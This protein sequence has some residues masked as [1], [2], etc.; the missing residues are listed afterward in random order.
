MAKVDLTRVL[1]NDYEVAVGNEYEVSPGN[2][3]TLKVPTGGLQR[4]VIDLGDEATATQVVPIVLDGLKQYDPDDAIMGM[5][6]AVARDFFSLLTRIA[7]AV[8]PDF[9]LSEGDQAQT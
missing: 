5:E 2:W 7:S 1:A 6:V 9:S 8:T 4:K 3:G